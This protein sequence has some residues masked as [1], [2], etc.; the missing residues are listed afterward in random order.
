[1]SSDEDSRTLRKKRRSTAAC[2][3][4]KKYPSKK[5][6]KMLS[7]KNKVYRRIIDY[8]IYRLKVRKV[9]RTSRE[10]GSVMDQIKRLKVGMSD[11]IF[12]EKDPILIFD[13]LSRFLTEWDM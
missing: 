7:C 12:D 1:M 13:F 11:L 9:Q 4:C 2:L 6:R 8:R 3:R 10:A 5:A